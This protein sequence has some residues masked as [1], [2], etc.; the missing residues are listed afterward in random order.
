MVSILISISLFLIYFSTI[1]SQEISQLTYGS[2]SIRSMTLL[3]DGKVLGGRSSGHEIEVWTSIN[4]GLSWNP[5]GTVS[6]NPDINYGDLMFL[7]I[8]K[9]DIVFCAFREHNSDNQFSV[10]VCRSDNNGIYL[11]YDSTVIGG[12]TLFVGL[13]W[14]FLTSNGDLQCYYDSE[15]LA[16]VNDAP[17]SQWI[18]MQ[19]RNGIIFFGI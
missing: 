3:N 9:T 11:V 1:I 7:A 8:P 2:A 5:I 16:S 13:P 4:H 10:V 15:P 18:A 17:G 6:N 12:Q 19:G 14:L